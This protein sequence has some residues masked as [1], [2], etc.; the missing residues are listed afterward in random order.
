M[1]PG[2]FGKGPPW[3]RVLWPLR[4]FLG[5]F[6]PAPARPGSVFFTHTVQPWLNRLAS[7][8]PREPLCSHS[9]GRGVRAGGGTHRSRR[10]EET[11]APLGARKGLPDFL[12]LL[13]FSRR[14]GSDFE[15][16][17]PGSPTQTVLPFPR[18][19]NPVAWGW[20][21]VGAGEWGRGRRVTFS[22][23]TPAQ[24]NSSKFLKNRAASFCAFR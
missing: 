10:G 5:D 2:D 16:L 14:A 11:V 17:E 6:G 4:S 23:V 24:I 21:G 19:W 18:A 8:P 3:G 12:P 9:S 13:Q 7:R 20:A 1:E 22:Q 15:T